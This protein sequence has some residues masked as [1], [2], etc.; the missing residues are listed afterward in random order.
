MEIQDKSENAF[1]FQI[2]HVWKHVFTVRNRTAYLWMLIDFILVDITIKMAVFWEYSHV[3][4]LTDIYWYFLQKSI[5]LVY[6]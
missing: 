3:I 5:E 1:E 4:I 6:T 2:Y